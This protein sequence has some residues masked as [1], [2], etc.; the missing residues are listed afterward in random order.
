MR[1]LT[2]IW[3]RFRSLMRRERADSELGDELRFHVERE[4]AAN[5]ASGMS[6]EEAR[7]AALR[8]FGGIDQIR[9][10]C[11][12]MRRVNWIQDFVQDVRYG[13]R[14]LRKAPG[15]T[16]VA[17]LTLALGIGANTAMF[18][19]VE[20]VLLR[21]LPFKDP[22][23]VL[24][25]WWA[26]PSRDLPQGTGTL[27]VAADYTPGKLNVNGP[28]A[29]EQISA[30]EVSESFFRVFAL[31]PLLGRT[32]SKTDEEPGHPP[33]VVLS[34]QLWDSQ[35][36]SDPKILQETI[37]I[38]GK[39]FTPVGVLR[40]GFDF[41]GGAQAWLPMPAKAEDTEFG[42]NT[43]MRFQIGR[44]RAGATLD[45]ARAELAVIQNREVGAGHPLQPSR[46]ET[47]HTFL[48]GDTG[49]AALLLFGAVG[50]ILLIACADVANLLLS[51]GSDRSRELAVRCTLGASR[52]RLI[53]Q[54]LSESILLSIIGGG[55]GLLC[56]WWAIQAASR[57]VPIRTA[58]ETRISLDSRVLAFTCALAIATGIIAGLAPA[59]Q[60]TGLDLS[61]ALKEGAR[62]SAE[63][64]RMGS[65]RSLRNLFGIAEIALALILAVGAT[66]FL[67]SFG[68]L[69]D[70]QPGFQDDHV[71]VAHFSLLG[72]K[73]VSGDRSAAFLRE[74]RRRVQA[75]P[76]VR[77]AGFVNVVPL[78][79]D[80][81]S[82]MNIT[83]EDGR[84]PPN[85]DR[86]P[87]AFIMVT[88]GYFQTMRIPLLAGRD[89]SDVDLPVC[90]SGTSDETSAHSRV[91]PHATAKSE[92]GPRADSSASA[93]K[94]HSE[95]QEQCS[96]SGRNVA[97]LS[98]SL[99]SA[100]WPG[101][102]A[103]GKHFWLFSRSDPP[104][105][106]VGVV[107]DVRFD[108]SDDPW[109]MMYFPAAQSTPNEGS[110]VVRTAG[111]PLAL[112]GS[113]RSVVREIDP[114]EPV[115]SFSTMNELL[116]KSVARPRFCSILLAVFGGLALVLACVGVYGVISYTVAQRTH[117]IG[118]R[119]ALGASRGSVLR[120]VAAYALRLSALGLGMGLIGAFLLARIASSFL[121]GIQATDALSFVTG[122]IA[123]AVVIFIACYVPARRAMQVDPMVALRHE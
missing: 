69:L 85:P 113:V 62:S 36:H 28:G 46:V 2:K 82:G 71:L 118:V 11:A 86:L 18:S 10:E 89:F 59:L 104:I 119:V 80:M 58:F 87:P 75:I 47:L 33:I 68:N 100:A 26:V 16:V 14:M 4:I 102:S 76:G 32:F 101:R 23:R 21:P 93:S 29:A 3:L 122:S 115:S 111:N 38:D 42:G 55:F 116:S 7:R 44:L 65:H 37:L 63:G 43:F 95:H 78:G 48:V 94:S 83:L 107:G 52:W 15:F 49:Q 96:S 105:E 117:E 41:P 17:V 79:S 120:M 72:P 27:Q 61:S 31:H 110:L 57:F 114:D 39:R 9:E 25:I 1:S 6:P 90:R 109:P 70:V 74:F 45:Q 30:A 92:S 73:Y 60:A 19:V 51:R 53:R 64:F 56:G 8:E 54:F 123:L 24:V 22:G 84:K 108:L 20:N 121:Y 106:V 77:S 98:E 40:R 81:I 112:V 13:A 99:A 35:F 50:F 97:I 103:V 91:Q 34:Q 66:L 88:P 5:I 12:D 67:R